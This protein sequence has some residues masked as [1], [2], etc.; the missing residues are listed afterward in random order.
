[1]LN[2]LQHTV[3]QLCLKRCSAPESRDICQLVSLRKRFDPRLQFLEM[4]V[5]IWTW[6]FD[7]TKVA[8]S[9]FL[10]VLR[11]A[12]FVRLPFAGGRLDQRR[13]QERDYTNT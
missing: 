4:G 13:G 1:M 9:V 2:D 6:G 5:N 12:C 8:L 11:P 3:S 7:E 10:D